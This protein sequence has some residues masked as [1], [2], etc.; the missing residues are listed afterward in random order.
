MWS[1]GVHMRPPNCLWSSVVVRYVS[2]GPNPPWQIQHWYHYQSV[3][4]HRASQFHTQS[5]SAFHRRC[6]ILSLWTLCVTVTLAS[7]HKNRQLPV[8]DASSNSALWICP[9]DVISCNWLSV[10]IYYSC[11]HIRTN[12]NRLIPQAPFSALTLSVTADYR[13]GIW[14]VKICRLSAEFCFKTNGRRNEGDNWLTQ[15]YVENGC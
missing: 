11:V 3:S 6:L 15:V 14:P 10:W 5:L 7:M 9:G 12:G 8:G 4:R 2:C 1:I 13:K